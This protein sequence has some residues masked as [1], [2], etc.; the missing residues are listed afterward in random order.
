VIGILTFRVNHIQLRDE[1]DCLSTLSLYKIS[2][3]NN[4]FILQIKV[5]LAIYILK[6]ILQLLLTN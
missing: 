2:T 5:N 4:L 6:L 3:L 1:Y